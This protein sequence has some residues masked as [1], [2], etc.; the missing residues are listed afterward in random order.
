MELR[1]Q[2]VNPEIVETD[3]ILENGQDVQNVNEEVVNSEANNA[4]EPTKEQL[5]ELAAELAEKPAAEIAQEVNKLKQQFH[6][7]RKKEIEAEKAEFIE[8]GN[9]EAA[10]A[11]RV[12]EL[13]EKFKEIVAVIKEKKAAY[14]AELEAQRQAN[15]ERNH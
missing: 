15:F 12:D 3:Q 1:E 10:F 5:I 2:S 11:P 4:E 7:I 9:E 13:E 8:K 14:I 6:A